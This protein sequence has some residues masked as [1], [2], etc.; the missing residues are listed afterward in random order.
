MPETMKT[1]TF[2]KTAPFTPALMIL[3]LLRS[4]S[5]SIAAR[6]AP[7]TAVP[8]V[9]AGAG[10]RF[11]HLTTDDGLSQG[12]VFA[13]LQDRQGFMWFATRD[14]LNRYDGNTFVVFKHNPDDPASLSGNYVQALLEDDHGYLWIGTYDGGVNRFDPATERFTRYRH[15]P[16]NS[17]S[18]SGDMVKCIARDRRGCLWFGGDTGLNRFDPATETFTRYPNDSAGQSVG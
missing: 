13:I 10:I 9:V 2:L 1:S 14:G 18:L 12:R 4:A 15:D 5:P 6:D 8:P 11:T 16:Q 7:G 3:M 17:N